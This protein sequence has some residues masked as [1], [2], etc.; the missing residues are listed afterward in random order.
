MVS[1]T[2]PKTHPLA[3]AAGREV[4]A[5][6]Q[7]QS[8]PDSL[9]AATALRAQFT[10]ELAAAALTQIG[11][12]RAARAKLGERADQLLFTRTGL[13]Q[14]SRAT[15]A[16]HHAERFVASGVRRVVDLGCGI[17][18]DAL[19][20]L[21]A[22]LE[23]VAVEA[24]PETAAV[25]QANLGERAEVLLGDAVELAPSL[26]TPGAAAYADPGRRGARGRSWRTEDLSPPW[27]FVESLLTR[28]RVAGVKLGPGLP[29][30][31]IPTGVE[32]EWVSE[33]G[34]TVEVGLWC[35]P[36]SL[37]DDRVA[38]L[39]PRDRL[40]VDR[41]ARPL[42]T[43]VVGS[44]IY[45]PAGAVI[46]AG[47]ISHLGAEL[48]AR[49]LHPD[50]AYLTADQFR[51]T[52]YATAF[53]VLEVHPYSEQ[54]LRQWARDRRIGTLEI[55]KRGIDLDPAM[56]RR[57]LKLR[58]TGSAT[59]IVTRTVEGAMLVVVRRILVAS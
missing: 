2:P 56:L 7:G 25:A 53:E 15:V 57:R 8:D 36:G 58:G 4:L 9:A 44:V 49:L 13:E 50:I 59:V 1:V 35:G 28:D 51:S 30:R 46:R 19:A 43:G 21:E 3:T 29:H 24:D 5:A 27:S 33:R 34:D 42:P 52:P 55:K 18:T 26:L 37:P 23:V 12:R 39:L 41:S 40:V 11:L 48:G 32:A 14:A 10:P 45:E 22:G 38:L 20:L 47:G 16:A 6:A 17:G 31:M 54:N